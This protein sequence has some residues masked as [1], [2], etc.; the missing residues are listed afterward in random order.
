M[1]R[2]IHMFFSLIGGPALRAVFV[3]LVCVVLLAAGRWRSALM[4]ITAT[5]GAGIIN[6]STKRL[7]RRNR[8][9]GLPGLIQPKD[10]S[11]PSGHSMGSLVFTG[12]LGYLVWHLTHHRVL[13]AVGAV[14]AITTTVL[15]GISR[16]GLHAHHMTDVLAGYALG[17]GWLAIVLRIFAPFLERESV[18]G[19]SPEPPIRESD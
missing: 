4:L 6:T 16:V 5:S 18:G 17:A 7:V 19:R 10:S 1:Q 12:A 8:P 9:Q 3:S 15:I 13:A 14:T 11:F 2:T